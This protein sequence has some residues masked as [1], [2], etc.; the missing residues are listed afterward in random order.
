[1]TKLEA[2]RKEYTDWCRAIGIN[3]MEDLSQALN[4]GRGIEFINLCEARQERKYAEIADQIYWN[5]NRNRIV[6]MAGP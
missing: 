3:T 6:M 1:M 4:E 5:K 2:A